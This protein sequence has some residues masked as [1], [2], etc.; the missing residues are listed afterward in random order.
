MDPVLLKRITY[1]DLTRLEVDRFH[2]VSGVSLVDM[3]R[4]DGAKTVGEDG[5]IS[6]DFDKMPDIALH[7]IENTLLF[8]AVK[9]KVPAATYEQ[10]LGDNWGWAPDEVEADPK[11]ETD[12]NPIGS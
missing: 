5:E 8:L 10:A 12:L 3:G 11:D 9:R 1:P 2:D 6:I 4:M 7:K